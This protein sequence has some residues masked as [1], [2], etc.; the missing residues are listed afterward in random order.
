MLGLYVRANAVSHR[1]VGR[2][3]VFRCR[4]NGN[5]RNAPLTTKQ[6]KPNDG[7]DSLGRSTNSYRCFAIRPC[8]CV[9][10]DLR[11]LLIHVWYE[12]LS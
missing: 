12:S 5:S 9:G 11:L 8:D 10:A 1:F 2:V 7:Q 3:V 4:A 6:G